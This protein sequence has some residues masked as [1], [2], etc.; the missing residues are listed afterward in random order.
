MTPAWQPTPKFTKGYLAKYA[1]ATSA[2]RV[3]PRNDGRRSHFARHLITWQPLS[4]GRI[5]SP[6]TSPFITLSNR[7]E[8]RLGAAADLGEDLQWLDFALAA[9][10]DYRRQDTLRLGVQPGA[11]ADDLAGNDLIDLSG[12][13]TISTHIFGG[14]DQDTILGV[15]APDTKPNPNELDPLDQAL[16]HWDPADAQ[17][18][19]LAEIE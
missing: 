7:D 14:E 19:W 11:V 17:P 6:L 3:V 15:T 4:A 2:G 9:C 12:V 10:A 8:L 13:N 1:M 5:S 18:H 16:A